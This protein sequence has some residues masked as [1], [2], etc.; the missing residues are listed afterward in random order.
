[1]ADERSLV[2]VVDDSPDNREMY[3]QY[4]EMSGHRVIEA[5]DGREAVARALSDSPHAIV[6]DL[7]LPVMTGW[8]AVARLK[9]DARTAQIPVLALS[10]HV[11]PPAEA[12]DAGFS[13]VLE[14]PC[15]PEDLARTVDEL[16]ARARQTHR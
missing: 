2:L 11:V 13:A 1:M 10:G 4:L 14:K 12:H 9:A 6:M 15:A 8:E 16:L 7:S 5:A 3:V